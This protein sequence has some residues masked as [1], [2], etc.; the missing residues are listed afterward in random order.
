MTR[1]I[2]VLTAAAVLVALLAIPGLSV[3]A[4]NPGPRV[5]ITQPVN[6]AQTVTL[7]GNTRPEANARF[8]RGL[9]ADTLALNHMLLQLKRAPEVESAF[10][11]YID[12]LTDKSSPNFRHWLT[13]AEQGQQFGVAQQDIDAISAWLESQGFSI[14]HVYPNHMVIDFSGTAGRI[15]NAFHT[16]IHNLQ[17]GREEHIANMSDPQVPAALAP[18]IHGVVSMHNFR[19]EA[20]HKFKTDYTFAGCG[21]NCYALV[22]EDFQTIYNLTPLYTAGITGK[23]QTVAVVEDTNTFGTDWATYRS[24]FKLA[25]YGGTLTTTHPN[26]AGNCT[27]PGTN[28]DDI[29]ADLDVQMVTA[30]APGAAVEVISCSD[31]TTTFGGLIAIQNIISAGS[32]PPIISMSYGLCEVVNGAAANAAFSSAFQ[33]AA[34]AGVSV[35]TSSGDNGPSACTRLF[36]NGDGIALPGIGITGWGESQYTVSVGGTDFEDLYIALNGG[37][38]QS[39]YW[40]S[41]NDANFGS[42]KSYIPEIPWND[43]CASYLVYNIEGYTSPVGTTGFCNS[44]TGS[45]FLSTVAGGGGP[46]G[47]YTGVGNQDFAYV[48]NTTCA[49]YPKPAFQKGVFGNPA[50]GVRNVPDVALFGSNGIWGHYIIICYA[51]AANGGVPCTGAPSGWVGIGGTSASAPLMA[52]IQ[53]LV[54]QHWSIRA[55][56]PN[57]TYYSIAKTQFGTKGNPTCYSI[58]ETAGNACVFNDITQGDIDVNCQ[59]NGSVFKADCY[60]P[61]GTN[62]AISTQ[63]IST[64]KLNKGGSGFTT[65]PNCVISIPNNKTKYT[66]PAGTTI[67]AGGTQAKCSATMSG[68]VVTAVTLTNAGSGYTGV[69]K[70]TISG[71]GGKGATC[72]ATI[73]PTA[74]ANSYQPAFG[75]T[76]GWDMATGL[77]S[78]NGF[79][80][81]MNSAW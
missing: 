62:G 36:T 22:P 6:N 70:C 7:Y 46:S 26:S 67:F 28:P 39:T 66:S 48:E 75:A 35:F 43:S 41:T 69:P 47:C 5:L 9:V 51:D 38:P 53:A 32:P 33:S 8:D 52:A 63:K 20:Y 77:G 17:V 25:T 65:A 73:T 11:A 4:A 37:T 27:N 45:N 34:A 60:R 1:K 44:T 13:A 24:K 58:N 30:A 16:E 80:L 40:K 76:P 29:E 42:A 54:N 3:L 61:S 21:T 74:S 14:N 10:E 50:D 31:T 12:S 78:V 64:L 19:P 18:A 56:N 68:G 72:T 81:V 71:G 2:L 79:N 59:F 49:G 15:R 23:G 57:P 55:G